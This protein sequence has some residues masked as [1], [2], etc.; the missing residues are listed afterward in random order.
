[1][2]LKVLLVKLELVSWFLQLEVVLVDLRRL[3][4][5]DYL[6]LFDDDGGAGD[7]DLLL[8]QASELLSC[9]CYA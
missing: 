9:L 3:P 8:E 7:L 1:M 5:H 4:L 6:V 2:R